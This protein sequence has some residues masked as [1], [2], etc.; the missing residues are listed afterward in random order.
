MTR[1]LP[2]AAI[3]PALLA[4]LI[5]QD[6]LNIWAFP[7]DRQPCPADTLLIMGAAQYDGVPSPVFRRRL[8]KALELYQTGCSERILVTGGKQPGDRYSEGDTGVRYLTERGVEPSALLT[9]AKSSTSFENLSFSQPLISSSRLL[10]I[11]DDLHSYRS[12]WLAQYLGYEAV[13][14]PVKTREGRLL[15]GLRELIIL[16]AY[17][18][19]IIR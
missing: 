4:L 13:I 19:G 14:A 11:T 1:L 9:E 12:K 17:R 3:L 2:V 6:A 5:S 16:S 15:Y 18:L 10:I 7:A 8:D